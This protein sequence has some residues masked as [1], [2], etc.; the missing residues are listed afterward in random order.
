MVHEW[1]LTLDELEKRA[2]V[3][4]VE[5]EWNDALGK[6]LTPSIPS[7]FFLLSFLCPFSFTRCFYLRRLVSIHRSP[8]T[9][10]GLFSS[11]W[12]DSLP[13][14]TPMMMS[15]SAYGNS[16]TFSVSFSDS[17]ESRFMFLFDLV[18][19]CS[20]IVALLIAR[21]PPFSL[22]LTLIRILLIDNG[23]LGL[24]LKVVIGGGGGA[25]G[26]GADREGALN[27]WC[28]G[29]RQRVWRH[30]RRH[31]LK[32]SQWSHAWVYLLLTA[33]NIIIDISF[34]SLVTAVSWRILCLGSFHRRNYS[35]S[36][37]PILPI[38]WPLLSFICASVVVCFWF[39]LF[40][41]SLLRFLFLFLFFLS[42]KFTSYV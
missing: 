42:P 13:C 10:R 11:R 19:V 22:L 23:E 32:R 38:V 2:A 33:I 27:A 26:V 3:I 8:F 34:S 25:E 6:V 18:W 24:W 41:F 35:L 4:T 12:F 14:L 39:S 30:R 36:I 21:Q 17:K 15:L 16:V 1:E 37:G 29:N 9:Y 40:F 7:F 31:S 28:V 20:R 5:N